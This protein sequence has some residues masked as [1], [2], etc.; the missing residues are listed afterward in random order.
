[1][2]KSVIRLL[3]GCC[4]ALALFTTSNGKAQSSVEL[5]RGDSLEMRYQ[6]IAQLEGFEDLLNLISKKNTT[7]DDFNEFVAASISGSP[8]TKLFY[9]QQVNDPK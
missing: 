5:T 7:Q 6:S 8:R 2:K 1:M 4:L 3:T 9:N